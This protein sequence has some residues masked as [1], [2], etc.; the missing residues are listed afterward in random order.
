MNDLEHPSIALLFEDG[1]I[2]HWNDNALKWLAQK[3]AQML[4]SSSWKQYY[5]ALKNKKKFKFEG[6]STYTN[7]SLNTIWY[8]SGIG[9]ALGISLQDGEIY[10]DG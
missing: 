4:L 5:Y 8:D 6:K 1:R 2:K 9:V 7:G 10:V 3:T